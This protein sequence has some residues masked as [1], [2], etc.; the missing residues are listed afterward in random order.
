MSEQKNRFYYLQAFGVFVILTSVIVCLLKSSLITPTNFSWIFSLIIVVSVV[1]LILDR[2]S[3]FS[4]KLGEARVIMREIKN[5]KERI[6][7]KAEL[8]KKIGEELADFSA[9][10]L[11]SVG[12]YMD[13]KYLTKKIYGARGKLMDL[14]VKIESEDKIKENI[15]QQIDE[16]IINDLKNDIYYK[17]QTINPSVFM[18]LTQYPKDANLYNFLREKLFALDFNINDFL[19]FLQTEGFND[20]QENA[21]KPSLERLDR[22]LKSK[23]L[24]F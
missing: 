20:E 23:T 1:I 22:F 19:G 15:I 5:E 3:E 6:Y 24:S 10:N 2:V 7:V 16:T 9:F 8:V 18:K 17:I 11:T 4:I 13:G 14:L 12:R 21:L